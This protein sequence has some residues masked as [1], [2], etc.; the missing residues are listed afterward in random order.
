MSE[1]GLIFRTH[2]DRGYFAEA[3]SNGDSNPSATVRILRS[4]PLAAGPE[5]SQIVREF[6]FPAYRVFNIAAHLSEIVDSEIE[7]QAEVKP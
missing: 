3:W 4:I 7:K 1:L 6:Y 5:V 2:P